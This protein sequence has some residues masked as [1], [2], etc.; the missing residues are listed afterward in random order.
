MTQHD[1]LVS[2]LLRGIQRQDTVPRAV[3]LTEDDASRGAQE[4]LWDLLFGRER[5]QDPLRPLHS[6]RNTQQYVTGIFPDSWNRLQTGTSTPLTRVAL[7]WLSQLQRARIHRW[8]SCRPWGVCSKPTSTS[9]P[10]WRTS[11]RPCFAT[12]MRLASSPS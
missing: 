7:V 5:R 8:W 10:S 12:A 9:C 11:S 3:W 6:G 4:D 1:C 2:S